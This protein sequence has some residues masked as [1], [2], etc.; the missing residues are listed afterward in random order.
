MNPNNATIDTNVEWCKKTKKSE[1]KAPTK[2]RTFDRIAD[3]K[4]IKD[5]QSRY[6]KYG[7]TLSLVWWYDCGSDVHTWKPIE[8]LRRSQVLT[9]FRRKKLRMTDD[10][11]KGEDC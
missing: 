8:H 3:H 11:A 7:D 6:A 10:I 1:K 2:E 5:Q 9:Y 4:P